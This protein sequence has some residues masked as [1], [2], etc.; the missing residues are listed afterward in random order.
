MRRKYSSYHYSNSCVSLLLA[1]RL[2]ASE[3]DNTVGKM[4]RI[5]IDYAQSFNY[6][7]GARD[8]CVLSHKS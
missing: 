3:E 7:S 2:I 8:D 1:R 5:K 4:H 6:V